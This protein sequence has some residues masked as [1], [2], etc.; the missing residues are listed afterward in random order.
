MDLTPQQEELATYYAQYLETD[1]VKKPQFNKNFF[2][3]FLEL[4]NEG[5]N[6]KNKHIIKVLEKC[7]F[8]PI[9]KYL[10]EQR[11][12][13]KNRSKEEKEKEKEE[14]KK[15]EEKYGYA[16]VDGYKQKIGNYK[17][18]PPGLFLGRGD[19]PKAGMLKKRITP[20]MV[21]LNLGKDAPI[22][23]C[24]VPGHNW[25]SVQNFLFNFFLTLNV[26][27]FIMMKFHG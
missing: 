19:H 10:M 14:K 27:L 25:G 16:I 4:L 18:E 15:I 21:T 1:H 17:V 22:P 26:R 2:D 24:P 6:S 8:T 23:E 11:E 9:H 20:E 12:K 13:K 3:Q 7:D 5:R